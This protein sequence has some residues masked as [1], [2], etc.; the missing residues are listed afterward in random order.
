VKLEEEGLIAGKKQRRRGKSHPGLEECA[1]L[2]KIKPDSC[3]D[4]EG[5]EKQ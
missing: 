4:G 2:T 5:K 3:Q 1:K